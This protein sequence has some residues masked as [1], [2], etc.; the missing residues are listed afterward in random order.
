[1]NEYRNYITG[2]RKGEK[3]ESRVESSQRA[4]SDL[5]GTGVGRVSQPASVTGGFGKPPYW[6]SH[7]LAPTLCVRVEGKPCDR[8]ASL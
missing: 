6:G 1:M 5:K 8:I 4:V 7:L 2:G 3:R